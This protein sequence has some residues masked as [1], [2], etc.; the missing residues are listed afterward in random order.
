MNQDR[1]KTLFENDQVMQELGITLDAY[2]AKSAQVSL[3]VS[4]KHTQGHG[5]CHGGIIFTLAD[6]AFAVACNSETI[7]VGQHC[8]ISYLKPGKIGDTLT[9]TAEFKTGSGRSEIYDISVTNQAHEIVAEFRGVS[10]MLV[11]KE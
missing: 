4:A 9:A 10:R 8:N 3:V 5:T 6:G 7:A 2:A 1:Q 11:T